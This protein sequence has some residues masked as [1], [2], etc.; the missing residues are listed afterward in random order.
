MSE[1]IIGKFKEPIYIEE[2]DII[3]NSKLKNIL[4]MLIF[5]LFPEIHYS[6]K[7]IYMRDVIKILNT[8]TGETKLIR[9]QIKTSK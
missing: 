9:E 1:V 2:A 7:G 3:G 5:L 8:Q 4:S 6:N